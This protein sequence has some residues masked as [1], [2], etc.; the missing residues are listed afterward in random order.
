V[1]K[2][3]VPV[4]E[5]RFGMY[6]AE[7]D[8]PWTET[9]F[10]FQGF[11]LSTEQQLE[12]LKKYCKSVIV[13]TEKTVAAEPPSAGMQHFG[14]TVYAEKVTVEQEMAPAR[15]AYTSS[16]TLVK[17]TLAK[18]RI[19]RNLDAERVQVAVKSL[20]ESVLRNPNAML[21]FSQLREKGEY[22]E[23]H[24]LDSSIYMTAFG[25]FLQ[26]EHQ[27]IE[28]LGYVGL[29]QDIGKVRLPKALLEKRGRLTAEEFEQAKLHVGYSVE[30][31]RATAGIP[32][33]LPRLAVLHH[34]RHDGSGYPNRLQ[35]NHIG[36][37]GS[38]AA[39]VDTYDAMTV[40]RPYAD[41]VAP[42]A[43]ISNLY[44]RRG[45]AFDAGLVEQFIRFLGIFPVGSLVELNSGEVGVVISQNPEQ[46]LKPRVMVIRDAKGI[47]LRPQ[48]LLDLS[49]SP[50][51][52]PEEPY[53]ILR[54]L[55]QGRVQ[56][57]SDQ[58]FMR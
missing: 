39:I 43:A 42:S 53:R 52:T 21:L 47:E 31:L 5:L 57:R 4:S 35:G 23:S 40:L 27:Q 12:A 51:A 54:T 55:E 7:L 46:R 37:I 33:E 15:S 41:P 1:L 14:K 8:R 48:K 25:R 2:K 49:R 18:V 50:K 44:K 24:S 9:P 10:R 16:H 6:I 34:E 17:E 19:G 56:V 20:T 30:I 32:I 45:V 26:L 11:L 29:L 38:I 36:L 28:L 3:T 13:D 58:L 22:A